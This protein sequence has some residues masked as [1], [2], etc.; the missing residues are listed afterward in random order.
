MS[1]AAPA[2]LAQ[3]ISEEMPVGKGAGWLL[4]QSCALIII[5]DHSKAT[6]VRIDFADIKIAHQRLNLGELP[7]ARR[8][9]MFVHDISTSLCLDAVY[10]YV[11]QHVSDGL[12]PSCI[13]V[14][15]LHL[16]FVESLQYGKGGA[17]RTSD[18]E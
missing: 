4:D 12:V 7:I 13:P 9:R 11:E 3:L 14:G 15:W 6:H 1:A 8:C 2:F 5:A 16:G 17:H 10:L 18:E